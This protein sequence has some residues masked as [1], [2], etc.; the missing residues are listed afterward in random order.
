MNSHTWIKKGTAWRTSRNR[1]LSA[2]SQIP[3]DRAV[4]TA[5]HM[6]N[7]SQTMFPDSGTWRNNINTFKTTSEMK[8]S[9]RYEAA[10]PTGRKSRGKYTLV[11]RSELRTKLSE[12][13]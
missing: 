2:D 10:A 9:T 3:T 6:R 1:T 13:P 12:A 4:T 8:K 5:R 11:I 7:G